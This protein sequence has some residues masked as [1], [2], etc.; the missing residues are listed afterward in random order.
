MTQFLSQE[1]I[2]FLFINNFSFIFCENIVQ[3]INSYLVFCIH[4]DNVSAIGCMCNIQ[5]CRI[6]I[7]PLRNSKSKSQSYHLLSVGLLRRKQHQ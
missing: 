2:A 7:N 3:V 1:R 5:A 4:Y 6:Y